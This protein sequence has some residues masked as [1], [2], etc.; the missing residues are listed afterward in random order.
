MKKLVLSLLVT[1]I[2]AT[3][4]SVSSVLSSEKV[5]ECIQE[6]HDEDEDDDRDDE[7][8]EDDEVDRDES[9]KTSSELNGV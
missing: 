2:L 9:L 6:E 8:D 3:G 7:D 1:L 5:L 4:C